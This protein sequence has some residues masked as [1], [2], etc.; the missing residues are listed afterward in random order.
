MV[1]SRDPISL[2]ELVE[3]AGDQQSAL[4][5]R[6]VGFK[7]YIQLAIRSLAP[8]PD[9]FGSRG[10]RSGHLRCSTGNDLL[11]D[12]PASVRE[13]LG[14]RDGRELHPHAI[15]DVAHERDVVVPGGAVAELAPDDRLQ[16]FP[17]SAIGIGNIGP[18][19]GAFDSPASA[20]LELRCWLG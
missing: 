3:E 16:I 1:P 14:M 19:D 13:R 8:D 20:N 9:S 2:L 6:E 12:G 11:Q 15:I 5:S 4:R 17:G 18:P 7:K 10:R